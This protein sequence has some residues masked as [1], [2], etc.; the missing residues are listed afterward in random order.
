MMK[1]FLIFAACCALVA[2]GITR[3]EFASE[4]VVIYANPGGQNP[5]EARA[6]NGTPSVEVVNPDGSYA[7]VGPYGINVTLTIGGS[8]ANAPQTKAQADANLNSPNAT[9]G[10]NTETP[11]EPIE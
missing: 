6:S 8:N 10:G 11:E 1:A 5:A 7:W 3:Y 2:C 9:T 4:S